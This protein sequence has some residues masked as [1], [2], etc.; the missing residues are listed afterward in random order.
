MAVFNNNIFKKINAVA[1]FY[2]MVIYPQLLFAQNRRDIFLPDNIGKISKSVCAENSSKLV[3]HIQDI[4]CNPAIQKNVARILKSLVTQ[5]HIRIVGIEGA[6]GTVDTSVFGIFP[7]R[8]IKD[9]VCDNFINKGV[10]TGAEKLSICNYNELDFQI[11]GVEDS[12]LYIDNLME[13]RTVFAKY[14]T[15][16]HYFDKLHQLFAL[17]KKEIYPEPLMD[18][19]SNYSRYFAEEISFVERLNY[20]ADQARRYNLKLNKYPNLLKFIEVI[21][22]EDTQID[23]D[24][25]VLESKSLINKLKG[26]VD[27]DKYKEVAKSEME[28]Q[29]GKI[30]PL[31]YSKIIAGYITAPE[32][33]NLDKFVSLNVLREEINQNRLNEEIETLGADLRHTAEK[34]IYGGLYE[35]KKRELDE[36]FLITKSLML[37][38]KLVSLQL[39]DTQYLLYKENQPE[40]R[41]DRIISRIK[42]LK[43]L[44]KITGFD[45]LFFLENVKPALNLIETAETFYDQ[46]NSRTSVMVDNLIDQMQAK[47]EDSAVLITGGYHTNLI[48]QELKRK[49]ISV[50]TI[51][52]FAQEADTKNYINLMTGNM[53]DSASYSTPE[54]ISFPV[55]CDESLANSAFFAGLRREFA[56]GLLSGRQ[57]PITE[58][59]KTLKEDT[60]KQ[61]FNKLLIL[62]GLG[63]DTQGAVTVEEIIRKITPDSITDL[64][65]SYTDIKIASELQ[66]AGISP[67]SISPTQEKAYI[68][69]LIYLLNLSLTL[70]PTGKDELHYLKR[71]F[72][73]TKT[74][75]KM[76]IH[77]AVAGE[78]R[79]IKIRQTAFNIL[80]YMESG[81]YL[82]LPESFQPSDI[83]IDDSLSIESKHEIEIERYNRFK[84][85]FK[86]VYGKDVSY[87]VKSALA[88]DREDIALTGL[89]VLG[90]PGYNY[91]FVGLPHSHFAGFHVT[92]PAGNIDASEFDINSPYDLEFARLYGNA[93][94]EAFV[95]KIPNR[96][97]DNMRLQVKDGKPVVFYNIELQ[98]S[99][100]SYDYEDVASDLAYFLLMENLDTAKARA[101]TVSFLKG[102][103][104]TILEIH[105]RFFSSY[106]EIVNY[107][108]LADNQYW[109]SNLIEINELLENSHY[110][111]RSIISV[112]NEDFPFDIDPREV[113]IQSPY[114]QD[115]LRKRERQLQFMAYKIALEMEQEQII[116]LSRDLFPSD[117]IIGPN[118]KVPISPDGKF[119][120]AMMF[121]MTVPLL[122][123]RRKTFF[124]KSARKEEIE[125]TGYQ[126]LKAF[127]RKRNAYYF[128]PQKHMDFEGF[129]VSESI[130]HED[131]DKFDLKSPNLLQLPRLLG[132][133]VGEAFL[134]GLTDRHE[135]N[136]RIFYKGAVPS[137][138]VN[139]DL[140]TI[141]TE[142]SFGEAVFV[143]ESL[144]FNLIEKN[145]DIK[146]INAFTIYYI[147]GIRQTVES[148]TTY[149]RQHEAELREFPGL[150][151]NPNWQNLLDNLEENASSIDYHIDELMNYINFNFGLNLTSEYLEFYPDENV[152]GPG[153][154]FFSSA[155]DKLSG[156]LA[157]NPNTAVVDLSDSIKEFPCA[158]MLDLLCRVPGIEDRS[159]LTVGKLIAHIAPETV[160]EF[161]TGFTDQA[162][163][164][165]IYRIGANSATI[166][167]SDFKTFAN[168]LV[169]ILNLSLKQ[170]GSS[171]KDVEY[172]SS[173]LQ[174]TS[175][176]G[177][178]II[179][180]ALQ[181]R[182]KETLFYKTDNFTRTYIDIYNSSRRVV[183]LENLLDLVLRFISPAVIRLY[184]A[185]PV[186]SYYPVRF[187]TKIVEYLEMSRKRRIEKIKAVAKQDYSNLAE[188]L[189]NTALQW[190]I[191]LD[192]LISELNL[193]VMLFDKFNGEIGYSRKTNEGVLK[194]L[195][196]RFLKENG[197]LELI[198]ES[199]DSKIGFSLFTD[200]KDGSANLKTARLIIDNLN[201]IPEDILEGFPSWENVFLVA[202]EDDIVHGYAYK[203]QL[204]INSFYDWPK[205][206]S[207]TIY[208][209]YLGHILV[210][211]LINN[212]FETG[213]FKELERRFASEDVIGI[214]L[215]SCNV[216]AF[217]P[218]DIKFGISATIT[219]G[220]V[221]PL[222]PAQ[223]K[224]II[225]GYNT[226]VAPKSRVIFKTAKTAFGLN[227]EIKNIDFN[228]IRRVQADNPAMFWLLVKYNMYFDNSHP[229]YK[230]IPDNWI[231]GISHNSHICE[232]I[233]MAVGDNFQEPNN[234]LMNINRPELRKIVSRNLL[235]GWL[236]ERQSGWRRFDAKPQDSA[237]T[238][239]IKINFIDTAPVNI[240]VKIKSGGKE[241]LDKFKKLHELKPFKPKLPG[242]SRIYTDTNSKVFFKE[243]VHPVILLKKFLYNLR[244]IPGFRKM[245][246]H[247][248]NFIGKY[249][250]SS[251]AIAASMLGGLVPP[252]HIFEGE[253]TYIQKKVKFTLED[254]FL[255][256]RAQN[257]GRQIRLLIDRWFEAQSAMWKRGVF[258]EDYSMFAL[259]YGV[260]N[261]ANP[262][263]VCFDVGLLRTNIVDI[264][265]YLIKQKKDIYRQMI[266]YLS[267]ILSPENLDYF[268]KK[269]DRVFTPTNIASVWNTQMPVIAED[270][271]LVTL[272]VVLDERMSPH[273][274]LKVNIDS[275]ITGF[276]KETG[277]E[278][279]TGNL[280][281]R[282]AAIYEEC[283]TG[284]ADIK[285][286]LGEKLSMEKFNL[287]FLDILS[288]KTDFHNS[289]K[290][291]VFQITAQTGKDDKSGLFLVAVY[292]TVT[293][294]LSSAPVS[295][296]KTAPFEFNKTIR[297]IEES[298]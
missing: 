241:E 172:I 97:L 156:Y 58:Y 5:N 161:V 238:P 186:L 189:K 55:L 121:E 4:H 39:T 218:K 269:Y 182:F 224:E 246:V 285:T 183:K 44:K 245:S 283:F 171:D 24:K 261:P 78:I 230:N 146:T 65:V 181:E 54:F 57:I 37:I 138:A 64:I 19:D 72:D 118:F 87:F 227:I 273:Y 296:K 109:S 111:L 3:V 193:I 90:R 175:V 124:V 235:K 125:E 38:K 260:D 173:A 22:C 34:R 242:W 76:S 157:D 258:D 287:L 66:S 290:K 267:Q 115:I 14:Q 169:S 143:L 50:V 153:S 248:Y 110:L 217:S 119:I 165:E 103:H 101:L 62:A 81:N 140:E 253:Q 275:Y 291:L 229:D 107:P 16:G 151:E 77:K 33:P 70:N 297:F 42:E 257:N 272:E 225:D 192:P 179:N 270:I 112:I 17:I 187:L 116:S 40:T 25:L 221:Q 293:D 27:E 279:E 89:K 134:L 82:K 63:S 108:G 205:E 244:T 18:I 213:D 222:S 167:E 294:Y 152:I 194:S 61:I 180:S 51:T 190:N 149:Y 232:L 132:H 11:V 145:I 202:N 200:F 59:A 85:S 226:N 214:L 164:E 196:Y 289:L 252:M 98:H 251:E 233:A 239:S 286:V 240:A 49:N 262:Y 31:Q 163:E 135:N 176:L 114:Y 94:A 255:Q 199:L 52:P 177:K 10:L 215:N 236:W 204:Y 247:L 231:A 30:S 256:Y 102:F 105:N 197:Y 263:V 106:Q 292:K 254:L 123:G 166:S 99:F 174:K 2:L 28:Y 249:Y 282:I 93:V 41:F 84:M 280:F 92:E 13:F 95:L 168:Y 139:I 243:S 45:E 126:V 8:K 15:N 86:D 73:S 133:A 219:E 142:Y 12:S 208:H 53:L 191:N 298:I 277:L 158:F 6:G 209:E 120:G 295:G 23:Y 266:D 32:Y 250:P 185:M 69:Y 201:L 7:D 206:V 91:N 144:I 159:Q 26:S 268:K 288:G 264:G 100:D 223:I 141:M 129:N 207:G 274:A 35:A 154:V 131:L 155:E 29:I 36:I 234:I 184:K 43:I 130:G 9:A 212:A 281:P 284:N 137:A 150:A 68:S 127:N 128:S 211:G 104:Q 96:T 79:L 210:N 67:E 265:S 47:K 136:I 88:T 60:A 259:N 56:T 276:L 21:N 113:I 178:K 228:F 162:I 170:T 117:I 147:K 80:K 216:S 160:M 122:N 75:N 188:E 46:A 271:D 1:L 148:M 48:E 198:G 20:L 74:L 83:T 278:T 71:I 237:G 203:L 220:A 195:D